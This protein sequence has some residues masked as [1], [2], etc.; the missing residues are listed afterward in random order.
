[1]SVRQIP[2]SIKFYYE[3]GNFFRVIHVDGAVGGMTPSRE[4]FVSLFSQR[5][6][7]PKSIELAVS[8]EGKLGAEISRDGKEGIFREMEIGVVMSAHAA[9]DLAQFLLEQVKLINESTFE[10][11]DKSVSTEKGK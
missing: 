4:V 11:Q 2:P 1:M 3:K 7:L 8:P 9:N 5:S 6:A 10:T